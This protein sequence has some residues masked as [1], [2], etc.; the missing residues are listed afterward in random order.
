MK[1]KIEDFLN[2][3]IKVQICAPDDLCSTLINAYYFEGKKEYEVPDNFFD[4]IKQNVKNE[5][6]R[7]TNYDK[8]EE[9]RLSGMKFDKNKDIENAINQY[10]KAIELGETVDK[11]FHAYAYA[12]ER[13]FVLLH[14]I[15]DYQAEYQYLEKYLAHEELNLKCHEKTRAK[16]QDRFDK[17]KNKLQQQ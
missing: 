3:P 4:I 11:M 6:L 16:Y 17:L 14:K 1:I 12:Y 7:K 15:K 9:F 13:I 5:E 10:S 8:I 2:L